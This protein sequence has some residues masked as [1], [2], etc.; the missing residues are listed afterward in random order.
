[1]NV[2]NKTSSMIGEKSTELIIEEEERG[3]SVTDIITFPDG[4]RDAWLAVFGS[5]LVH[6]IVIGIPVTYGVFQQYYVNNLDSYK[7]PHNV[8]SVSIIGSVFNCLLGLFAI[9]AGRLGRYYLP[10]VA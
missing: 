10:V 6:A 4:G 1:M 9:P 5:W 7:G 2:E 3:K 8:S